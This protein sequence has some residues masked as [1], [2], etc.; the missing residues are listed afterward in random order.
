MQA[1]RVALDGPAPGLMH[2]RRVMEKTITY[3]GLDV[4]K[5]TIAVALAEAG[6]RGEVRVHGKIPN[7]PAA[8]TALMTKLA[9]GKKHLRFCYEAGPCGY[10]IQRQLTSAGHQCAVVAPSLIPR[11]PGERIKTDRRDAIGC[12][13]NCRWT[14]GEALTAACLSCCKHSIPNGR[15]ASVFEAQ[16]PEVELA[17]MD[18]AQQLD[19]ADGDRRGPEPLETEHRTKPQLDPT[20]ILL[21]Q[22]VQ[23]FRRAQLGVLGQR[24][25]SL[26]LAHRAMRRRVT[27]KGDRPRRASLVFDRLAEER[28]GRRHIAPG[29]EAKV[30]RL[31]VAIDRPIQ[32]HPCTPDFHVGLVN[33]PRMPDQ[34]SEPVPAPFELRCV[35]LHP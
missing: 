30:Y 33:T 8:L 34:P 10:G 16:A 29:A 17:L 6:L 3:V 15:R 24:A 5:D 11:K 1:S 27:V 21:D 31:A 20:V 4:H 7:T 12:G 13:A 25:I 23:V 14:R 28:L 35:V 22:V 9:A 32:I 2:R 19:A 26:H 18:P